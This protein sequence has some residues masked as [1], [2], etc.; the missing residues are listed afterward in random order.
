[1]D[2]KAMLRTRAEALDDLEQQLRSEADVA[3]ERIV[4]TENGFRLQETETFTV[5]VWKMLFNWRLVVMPPH[6]QVETTHGYCYFGTGLE[7]LARA[8][9][10]GLQWADPMNTAPEGFDKQAF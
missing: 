6:Q 9:A 4:R 1:M 5:E 7:S 10:A 8:V 2:Q 3:G